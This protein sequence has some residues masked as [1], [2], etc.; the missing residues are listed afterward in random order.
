MR[1]PG[2]VSEENG[3]KIHPTAGIFPNAVNFKPNRK[4]FLIFCGQR[5]KC[6]FM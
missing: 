2:L 6:R 5:K 3:P 1:S 4:E